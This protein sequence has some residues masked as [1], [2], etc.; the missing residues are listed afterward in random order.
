VARWQLL[1][2]GLTADGIAHRVR[3]GRLI[4]IHRGVYAV[5]TT[6]L[7][8][9]AFLMAAV[10][11]AGP[12]AALSHA[13]A[14]A[15]WGIRD[16]FPVRHHVSVPAAARRRVT[17]L[18]LSRRT[19]L[20][21][22]T[23]TRRGIP[24][25]NPVL[26]LIDLA[27]TLRDDDDVNEAIDAADR[28]RLVDPAQLL[29]ALDRHPGRHGVPRLRRLLTHHTRVDS[30]L[31]RRFLALVRR[32][33]LPEPLTQRARHGHRVDFTW[34]EHGV[35]VEA[36]SLSYHRT[37][38][39]QARDIH[40]DNDLTVND[41]RVL[42]FSHAQVARDPDYVVRILTATLALATA[43]TAAAPTTA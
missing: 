27:A 2:R 24:I 33:G 30:R 21:D 25:T 6:Q 15:V 4:R 28:L 29:R 17:G 11:A 37:A 36:D 35:V 39:A 18:L 20:A 1:E 41:L 7:D 9:D 12:G 3:R 31:E 16:R 14:A 42:R 10:L 38:A 22:H 19:D 26:T 32:A 13:S 43:S 23:T 34:P 5:G 40:R 8:P